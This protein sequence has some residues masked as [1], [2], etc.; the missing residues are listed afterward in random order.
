M[1]EIGVFLVVIMASE[2][3]AEIFPDTSSWVY[4][5][6]GEKYGLEGQELMDYVQKCEEREDRKRD[7]ELKQ[8]ENELKLKE[9]DLKMKEKE[10]QVKEEET[11]QKEEETKQ[12]EE[13]TRQKEIDAN[14]KEKQRAHEIAMKLRTG[15]SQAPNA[16]QQNDSLDQSGDDANGRSHVQV[17]PYVP[18]LP[19]FNEQ[20]D[21]MDSFI[22]RFENHAKMCGW[23]AEHWATYFAATLDGEALNF[24]HSLTTA[25]PVAYDDVKKN[26]MLKYQCT[27][28]GFRT[29]F[30][31]VRPDHNEAILSYVAKLEHF[32]DGWIKLSSCEQTYAALR[33]LILRE[34]FLQGCSKDLA[35]FL[36]ERKLKSMKELSEAAELYRSAHP[37]KPISKK[38]EASIFSASAGI[39]KSERPGLSPSR[40]NPTVHWPDQGNDGFQHKLER[41]PV[42]NNQQGWQSRGRG[43]SRF[44]RASRG[45]NNSYGRGGRGGRGSGRDQ[46]RGRGEGSGGH[47]SRF[48][49][50]RCKRCSGVGHWSRDCPSPEDVHVA[51]VCEVLI[52]MAAE[53]FPRNLPIVPGRVNDKDVCVLRDTGC[54]TAGIRQSLV[55]SHQLTGE[56]QS[57]ISFGGHI[58]EFPVAHVFLSSSLYEGY[59][60]CCVIKNPI[61]DVILGNVPGVGDCP[62]AVIVSPPG[63]NGAA[64][65]GRVDE[66]T[67][68]PSCSGGKGQAEPS[69]HTGVQHDHKTAVE[70]EQSEKGN[71]CVD[72]GKN[73]EVASV[74]TRAQVKKDRE[75]KALSVPIPDLGVDRNQLSRLQKSDP[76]LKACFE[77]VVPDSVVPSADRKAVFQI[78]DGILFRHFLKSN[79]VIRQI[80][81]PKSL[82]S[83]VLCAAHDGLMAGHCGVRRTLLRVWSQFFWPGVRAEVKQHCASCDICQKT[84]S[85]GRVQPVPLEWM[86][87]VDVPF[88][89][90]AVD[91]VGPLKPSDEGHRFILTVIDVATRFPEAIPLKRADTVAV[92]EALVGVFSRMGCPEEILSDCGTQFISDL[93]KE[94]YRL[95]SIKSVHTSPYHAQSNGLCE[96][97]NGT[98]KSMLKKVVHN[99]PS[100][101]HRYLAPLLFAYRELPTDGTGFSP[102]EL[103][104]GRQPR[105]PMQLLASSWLDEK[106]G[107]ESKTLYQYVLDLKN[108][109]SD[110][111]KL[112]S[113]NTQISADRNK[114]FFDRKAV[115]R[116]F[117]LG[118]EVLVLLPTNS[119]KLLMQWKG[120]IPVVEMLGSDY[121]IDM[122]GKPKVFHANMLKKYVRRVSTPSD[123]EVSAQAVST[124]GDDGRQ[125]IFPFASEA[126]LPVPSSCPV[127][128]AS[129]AVLPVEEGNEPLPVSTVP[130]VSKETVKD[131]QIDPQ[132]TRTQQKEMRDIFQPFSAHLTDLPGTVR[133]NVFHHIPLTVDAVVRKKPYPVPFQ[134]HEVFEKEVQGIVNIFADRLSR[135][136]K[137][138]VLP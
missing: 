121:R 26:F 113:E 72:R 95:L 6:Q 32:L 51:S 22:T 86:P 21:S 81:V 82:R 36:Q 3:E 99:H 97:F 10:L 45:G 29:R 16:S 89:R 58:E 80:V 85:K 25:G 130:T 91:L 94:I 135:S 111:W 41:S 35:I 83:S 69:K 93:M 24:Y 107:D 13:E 109:L 101:W 15:L 131:V 104:F 136:D 43:Q 34:Q 28:E 14:E 68:T 100:H 67:E 20:K 23:K 87:V 127:E 11:K 77:A 59:L 112:A 7:R 55:E 42:K 79:D 49:R 38:S 96:R 125:S 70:Q 133:G 116:A 120:P 47:S 115:P 33:D 119:S 37:G 12:K 31:T 117:K 53:S 110:S 18:K 61:A 4:I 66:G 60:D 5:Q 123:T 52:S 71:E 2:S 122:D 128:Y 46:S 48:D 102:Y 75:I 76:S 108:T 134:S 65:S 118:D 62:V 50:N 56:R 90:I 137:D 92:A 64:S 54:T 78:H 84:V 74:S 105:G 9:S 63:L 57:C 124:S 30:R 126:S 106:E 88:K 114:K 1:T 8:Q 39:L 103:L 27:E 19:V 17:R 132:L 73:C 129:V 40:T 44:Q 98:L 138:Q